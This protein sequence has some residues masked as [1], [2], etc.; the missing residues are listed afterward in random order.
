MVRLNDV[1]QWLGLARIADLIPGF[2]Y[3]GIVAF[4]VDLAVA[5]GVVFAAEFADKT[6]LALLAMSAR[7]RRLQIWAGAAAAF[8]I[9]TFAA[10]AA[11]ELL[12][13]HVP[14]LF[15]SI[16]AGLLFI[17][18]GVWTLLR[19]EDEEG[20]VVKRS[21]FLPAFTLMLVAELG[22]KTQ[23]SIAAL[24]AESGAFWATAVGGTAALWAAS[25][26]AVVAGGWLGQRI[27]REIVEQIAAWLFIVIGITIL[28]LGL[29]R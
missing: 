12:D 28:V 13:R 27:R 20:M 23:L 1:G 17:G 6:Q 14:G 3:P 8:M 24:A 4:T 7:G 5:F 16:L 25:G 29:F 18:F 2:W 10:A 21:G 22:D 19:R 11:G 9:L 26:V 15:V